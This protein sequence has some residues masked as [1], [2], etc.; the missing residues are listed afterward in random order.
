MGEVSL[1]PVK[2]ERFKL[3]RYKKT[4]GRAAELLALFPAA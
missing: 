2:I 1:I 3:A 4:R